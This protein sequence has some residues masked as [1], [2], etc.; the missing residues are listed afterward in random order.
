MRVIGDVHGL[1]DRYV[2]VASEATHSVQLGD[3]GFSN[4]WNALNYSGLDPLNHKIIAGNHCDY[5]IAPKSPFYLG[6]FGLTS[7]G[8]VS[9][10]FVRGGI[11]IDRVNRINDEVVNNRRSWWSQE[12]LNF[13]EMLNCLNLY[14]K[15]KPSI[16]ISH[17]PASRFTPK[18]LNGK[19]EGIL[20]AFKFHEGF[21]E[22]TQL[23]LDEMIKAHK[24]D[25]M[26]SGHI[27]SSFRG[28]ISGVDVVGLN[29][30]EYLD[31]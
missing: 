17:C 27:H 15:V 21:R 31:L 7:L 29:E 26:I 12:E 28:K 14:K 2:A 30:L 5:D 8:G 23:L 13:T 19:S 18:I 11:S 1:F 24:P 10:F 16:V 9:F 20:Q 4:G 25:M 6:D 3:F 22:N